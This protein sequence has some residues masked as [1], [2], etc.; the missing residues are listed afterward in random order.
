MPIKFSRKDLIF[1]L[2]TGFYT[3][4]I[5]WQIL[6]F[7]R[8]PLFDEI[9]FAWFMILVPILWI[10]GVN[11]GYFL[12]RR[13]EFFNQFGKF[14]AIGFTNAAVDFGILDLLIFYSGAATGILFPIFKLTSFVIASVHSYFWNKYWAFE[15]GGSGVSSREFFKFFGVT[16]FAILINVAAASIIVNII[17]PQ[18]GFT[19]EV[20][21]NIAAVIGSATALMASFIG[22][23]AA[24]FKKD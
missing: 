22:F 2:I 14:A 12:G 6:D 16:V 5:V 4:F 10:L 9:S 24:V 18:F 15:A 17:E 1:S 8:V 3:G 21:A 23:R 11:L 20:W 13:F 7:L 19:N